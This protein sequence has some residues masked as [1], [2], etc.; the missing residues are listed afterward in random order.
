MNCAAGRRAP[1]WVPPLSFFLLALVYLFYWR[2]VEYVADDWLHL[3]FYL[4]AAGT[5]LRGHLHILRALLENR[6]YGGFQ[7]FWVSQWLNCSL[8]WIFGY[9]PKIAFAAVLLL[10]A[11]NAWLFYALLR[12]LRAGTRMAYL[13]AAFAV[14]TPV[15]HG[16]LFWPVNCT[17]FVLPMFWLFLYLLQALRTYEAGKL[18]VRAAVLQS[19]LI[20]LVL[21]SGSPAAALLIASPLWLAICFFGRARLRAVLLVTVLNLAVVILAVGGYRWYLRSLERPGGHE[22]RFALT[23]EYGVA[24]L[25]MT[26]AHLINLSGLTPHSYYRLSGISSA[27]LLAGLACGLLVLAVARRLPF[28]DRQQSSSRLALFAAGMWVLAYAP[29]AFLNSKTLRHYYP[30]S[31]FLCLLLALPAAWSAA[32][33]ARLLALGWGALL[34]SYFALCTAAEIQQCWVPES[35][36]T[37]SLKPA[38]RE[39]DHLSP[40]DWIIAPG[41]PIVIGTAPHFSL[42]LEPGGQNFARYWTG[43]SG[44]RFAREIVVERGRLR[45]FHQAFMRDTSAEELAARVHVIARSASGAYTVRRYVAVE[46]RPGLYEVLPLKGFAA[47]P[48]RESLATQAQLAPLEPEIYYAKPFVHGDIRYLHY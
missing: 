46:R 44:L 23:Y 19:G 6:L 4:Q 39:L 40:G 42:A 32:R 48:G 25:R 47:L 11:G 45:F 37:Q 10:H 38:L 34:C 28:A 5:G 31:F 7:L 43:V 22:A 9:A 3:N 18:T 17:F 21:F 24:G 16:P 27:A 29:I 30:F 33:R 2:N 13:A 1:H 15:A 14:L 26:R 8:V 36:A 35:L 12:R 20:L 41:M